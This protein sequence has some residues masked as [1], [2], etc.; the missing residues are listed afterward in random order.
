MTS[1]VGYKRCNEGLIVKLRIE[2]ENNELRSNVER[3]NS[4]YAKHRCSKAFVLDIYYFQSG[5]ENKK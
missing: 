5:N 4:K 3:K 2:G 1:H